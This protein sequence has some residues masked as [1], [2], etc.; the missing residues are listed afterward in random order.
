MNSPYIRIFV[1][2][3]HI[4][5]VYMTMLAQATRSDAFIDILLIDTGIRRKELLTL[6]S[7][8]SEFHKWA[9]VHNFSDEVTEAHDFKPSLR[10]TITRK[11]KTW[12]GIKQ[13]YDGMLTR[14]M[15]KRDAGY[16]VKL[17][18]LLE[19]FIK[20]AQV[21]DLYLMTQTYLNRPLTQLF[22][23]AS[24]NYMEHGI[25]D[26]YYILDKATPQGKM[27]AVFASPYRKYLANLGIA[28]D[29][30][31]DL[32]GK[33][34]FPALAKELLERHKISLRT[35]E[36]PLPEKPIVYLLLEA[37]DMYNVDDSF[38][39][40][41]ID[42]I[43][44][45][46][47]DP[48]SY[49]FLLKPHPMHSKHSIEKTEQYFGKLGLDYSI[50]GGENY[51]SA[52]AEVLFSRWEDRTEHVF[53]LFSSSC[54]YLSQLYCN[55]KIRYYYSTEFMSRYIDNAPPQYYKLYVEIRPLIEQVFAER[56]K[57]Y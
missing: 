37:V 25:G 56:C 53:C 11:A 35:D 28:N 27:H 13:V 8:T 52:A 51:S 45:E 9:L 29:W 46:L 3:S 36:L 42:H 24:I 5:T 6:I 22:S 10:K 14:Y 44:K 43:L 57:P 34:K 15:N 41:Y 4:S 48:G 31:L 7:E 18:Q 50:L 47:K 23:G 26:Y 19:P 54:F 40:A 33:D 21:S 30:V 49:H 17:E 20:S 55:P 1:T 2:T 12:P 39:T 32:P 38:W 16:G